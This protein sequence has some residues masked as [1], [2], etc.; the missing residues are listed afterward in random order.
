MRSSASESNQER[1][2][3]RW[4]VS[5]HQSTLRSEEDCCSE[6]RSIYRTTRVTRLYSL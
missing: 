2:L 6:A 1:S 3:A 4:F 5:V